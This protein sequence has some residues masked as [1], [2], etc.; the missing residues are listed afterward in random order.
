MPPETAHLEDI[1]VASATSLGAQGQPGCET[2]TFPF[3]LQ[4]ECLFNTRAGLGLQRK[5]AIVTFVPS[6]CIVSKVRQGRRGRK[7][8]TSSW[9]E[10]RDCR[11]C[12]R[13]GHLMHSCRE[14]QRKDAKQ[15]RRDKE[16]EA[17]LE[18][19]RRATA[20]PLP[21]HHGDRTVRWQGAQLQVIVFCGVS[22]ASEP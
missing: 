3:K 10:V 5:R 22:Q 14:K 8:F 18:D 12:G 9:V 2:N 17:M 13:Q 20:D 7:S 16:D 15:E 1:K 19:A 11:F 6:R 21:L 4:G